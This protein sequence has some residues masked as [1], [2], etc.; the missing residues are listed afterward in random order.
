MTILGDRSTINRDV[1]GRLL[2]S[3]ALLAA[4]T[5]ATLGK[6]SRLKSFASVPLAHP[7][8]FRPRM[9][10]RLFHGVVGAVQIVG[11]VRHACAP[12]AGAAAT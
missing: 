3:F 6:S 8:E 4:I 11:R 12:E 2:L 9:E 7:P 1:D 10:Y 5:L